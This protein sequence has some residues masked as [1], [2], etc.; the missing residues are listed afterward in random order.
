MY[1]C[2]YNNLKPNY[3]DN[4]TLLT[5]D[6]DSFMFYVETDDVCR[7]IFENIHLYDTS[8]YPQNHPLFSN[9]EKKIQ[10]KKNG[11]MIYE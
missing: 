1:D 11:M 5:T 8:N 2:Y 3:Q 4:L 6:T 9:D 10:K 7:D